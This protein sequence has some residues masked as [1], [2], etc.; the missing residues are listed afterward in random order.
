MKPTR[1]NCS[2]A[3]KSSKSPAPHGV[4]PGLEH[5]ETRCL[6]SGYRP[7]DEFA[8]NLANPTWGQAGT[9]LL[10]IAPAAYANGYSTPSL[11][12]DPGARF[13]SNALNDQTDPNNPSQ[14]LNTVYSRSLSDFAYAWGKFIDHDMDL[15]KDNSGQRFDTSPGSPTDPMGTEPF[16]RSQYD[17]ATG[18]GPGNPRQQI[19]SITSF[20]DL[21]QVYGSDPATANALRSHVG[22]RMK[23]SPGALLP[24]NN[25]T[26]FATPLDMANDARQ[27]P[28]ANLFA[29]G[30]RRA[31]ENIELTAIQTLFVRNHN[32]I[33]DELH[34]LHPTWGDGLL[35]QEARKINIATEEII[36]YA[37][38]LPAILGPN[39]LPAYA[40]YNLNVNPN[41]ATEFSTALFRFGHSLLSGT[42]GR[43]TNAGVDIADV[44]PN[45][46]GIDLAQD[47]F[48]P[49][50]ISANGTTDPITGH[51]SSNIGPILKAVADNGANEM[52]LL[53]IRQ[54]RNLLFGQP[55]AGGTDLAACDVQRGRDH[56]L[57]DYNTMWAY[58]GLPRVTSFARITS[59]VTVQQEL[60]QVYGSVDNIDAF[61]GALAEDHVAGADVG[62]LIKAGL[63]DQFR[64]LRDG[65]RYFYL[66]ESFSQEELTLLR[67]ADALA[68]A[69]MANT[70]ITNLQS[71]VF[72]FK[73]SISGTVF[74]DSDGDGGHQTP[75]EPGLSGLTVE[76]LDSGGNVLATA[77]PDSKGH[78]R[79]SEQTGLPGS[80]NF[81]VVLLV[82]PNMHQTTANPGSIAIGR[83]DIAATGVDFGVAFNWSG[84]RSAGGFATVP[85]TS[86]V[87]GADQDPLLGLAEYLWTIPAAYRKLPM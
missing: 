32:C 30:D 49:N 31:N 34:D 48:D 41:I 36:T 20:L 40:G 57:P 27:V 25:T 3:R 80:G 51:T 16:T 83:G 63:V 17:P 9:D 35:Y 52:D 58:Y 38:F 78:F 18:T 66:N 15:T 72:F 56:V 79:L 23:T 14:D 42:V 33:A 77:V 53:L 45:G 47:F 71:N 87:A 69:I 59:N 76:L 85:T 5:L 84:S 21:S 11:A 22:G 64:R 1:E 43:N 4:R 74:L 46:A 2:S 37:E 13:I 19:N 86:V 75:G 29:A 28:D 7:I 61:E 67:Q 54:A 55:G 68:K 44:N 26:Y 73:A 60:Q 24:Y 12:N 62:P 50:L 8:N 39:A 6:L 10:R 65:D 81:T 82:P 70:E